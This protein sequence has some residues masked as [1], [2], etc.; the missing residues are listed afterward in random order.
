[1][2][3][4]ARRN[5]AYTLVVGLVLL[6][7]GWM[8]R[9][10]YSD[11]L[12]SFYNATLDVFFWTLRFGGGVFV[13]IGVLAFGGLRAALL[14]DALASAICGA[15]MLLCGLYWMK[16]IGFDLSRILF[17]FFGIMF[18]RAA[19]GSFTLFGGGEPAA[20]AADA[21]GSQEHSAG[22]PSDQ[23]VHPASQHPDS[24]P[25]ED[26]PPPPEGYLAALSK[27]K[28]EPPDAAFK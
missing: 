25:G 15:V 13:V 27:D 10:V 4:P 7:Y 12:G 3:E 11:E 5:A 19:K 20:V 8:V 18:L 16:E 1:M 24:L 28:T 17:V 26:Q 14:L 2:Y 9:P 6:L 23:S 22:I 21:A